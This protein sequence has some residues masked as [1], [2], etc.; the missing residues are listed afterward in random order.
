MN[1]RMLGA[2]AVG[3]ALLILGLILTVYPFGLVP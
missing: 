3:V 2:I 1:E